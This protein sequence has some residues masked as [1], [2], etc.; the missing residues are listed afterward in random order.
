MTIA[1]FAS[2]YYPHV[3]GVEELVRQLVREYRARGVAAIVLTNRWPRDLPRYELVNDAPVYRVPFRAPEGSNTARI[4]YAATRGAIRRETS[5]VLRRH[6]VRL[7]HVQ[8]VSANGLYAHLAARELDLPLIVTAQGERL[9]DASRVYE[10]SA[11]QNDVLRN[12]LHEAD[13]ITACSREVLR[14]LGEYAG[15]ALGN[16]AQV[17]YNG[18]SLDDFLDVTIA[19]YPHPRP[20]VLAVGRLVHQKGFDLLI[21]AFAAAVDRD[22]FGHDLLL[23]GDGPE[24][25]LL[26]GLIA[27]LNLADRVHLLGMADRRTVVSLYKGCSFFALPS[28]YEP[29]GIVNLESM[30]AGKAIVATRVGGVSEIVRDNENGLLVDPQDGHGLTEALLLLAQ[31]ESLRRDLGARGQTDVEAFTWSHIAGQYLACYRAHGWLPG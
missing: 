30:A 23:A 13:A 10:R 25:R 4:T 24:R 17:I 3:G 26:A 20:Y 18:V 28:R 16:R 2:A 22:P 29:L 14:D 27:D 21:R 9:M 5:A 7:V 12:L 6:A 1:I 15:H 8:C 19:A 31:D 11:F